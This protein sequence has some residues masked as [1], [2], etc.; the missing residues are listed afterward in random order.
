MGDLD[1]DED[2]DLAFINIGI[3]TVTVLH[4]VGDG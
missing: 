3:S 1:G 2:I 4:N